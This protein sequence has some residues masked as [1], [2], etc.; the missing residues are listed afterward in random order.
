MYPST[1]LALC[2][3]LAAAHQITAFV[4]GSRFVSRASS[5]LFQETDP[6]FEAHLGD[7]LKV[8]SQE[9][10][11]SDI[12]S[13]LRQRFQEIQVVKRTAA[14][15]LKPLNAELAAELEEIA[16]EMKET[17]ERFVKAAMTYDAWNRP[18][19]ELPHQLRVQAEL[20]KSQQDP[21]FAEHLEG[22]LAAGRAEDRPSP[23]IA[24]ELRTMTYSKP[25]GVKRKAALELRKLDP[26]CAIAQSLEDIAQ[27]MDEAH[28]RFVEMAKNRTPAQSDDDSVTS[29]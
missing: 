21:N 3:L 8:G 26:N 13:K 19:P 5:R 6:N 18:D 10:P 12:G 25:S 15:Q 9:R 23:E 17:H 16:D 1:L 11:A 27:E 7:F 22:F 2:C 28:E 4:A 20:A 24:S 14:K 29:R